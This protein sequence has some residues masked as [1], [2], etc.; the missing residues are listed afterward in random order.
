[1]EGGL[2][3]R[4][5]AFMREIVFGLEDS[6]V[7]TL[8]AVT[9]I[10]VGTGNRYVVIL[11]GLVLIAVE[12]L[13]MSA[14]SYLSSKSA[15]EVFD[16]RLKQDQSRL[17]Q[18]R[19]DDDTT[20]A[21][22]LKKAKLSAKDQSKVLSALGKERK[23]WMKEVQRCEHRFAP[24]VSSSPVTSGIVMGLFYLLGGGIPLI[25]YLVLPVEDAMIPSI[26]IT[27]IVLFAVGVLKARYVQGHWLKSGMEMM[28]VSLTAAL[29]GFLI[30]NLA[31]GFLGVSI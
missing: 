7:S 22:V 21:N 15:R 27:G 2:R 31:A 25:A 29:L 28:L 12:A 18:E 9:G 6:L 11:S 23:L 8:G 4:A 20:F 3:V 13:S 1:M 14:G 16:R 5:G 17:L 26:V 24:A 10:A 30:G 19:V